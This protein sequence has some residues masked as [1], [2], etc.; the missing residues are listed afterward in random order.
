ML[1]ELS[2]KYESNGDIGCI[3]SGYGDP[4]GKSYGEYQLSSNAGSLQAFVRWCQ[5]QGY[6]F[7]DK[8]A[9]YELCSN[10]FDKTW[11]DIA[12][13]H[14][15]E[16]REAQHEYIKYAYYDP[17]IRELADNYFHIENHAEV[18]KDVVWSRS[19]QYG[20][21]EIINMFTE[22]CRTMYNKADDDYSGYPNMS[23]IDDPQY[24]YDFIVAI[25]NVCKTPEWNS[26]SLRESLN[27]RFNS[28]CHDALERL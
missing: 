1:G 6:S 9:S 8:L 12:E 17:A 10:D 2:S 16:F 13:Y 18:M 15:D 22:A 27:N 20:P 26:T 23:Y 11:E 19:V 7:A 21:G 28:E 5:S 25:Y 4:G 3:S 14:P 24:D